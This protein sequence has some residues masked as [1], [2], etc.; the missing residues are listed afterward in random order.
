MLRN[1]PKLH[2]RG[3]RPEIRKRSVLHVKGGQAFEQAARALEES[4]PWRYLGDVDMA[5]SDMAQ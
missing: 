3:F 2:Q 4:Y 1:D 5:L